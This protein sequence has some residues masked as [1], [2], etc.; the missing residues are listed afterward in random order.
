MVYR[1]G[2][3]LEV[4]CFCDFV[5]NRFSFI[6]V[7]QFWLRVLLSLIINFVIAVAVVWKAMFV[8]VINQS[9]DLLEDVLD[10]IGF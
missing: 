4:D 8:W 6:V 10:G 9:N 1:V 7:K 2:C 3:K 5:E